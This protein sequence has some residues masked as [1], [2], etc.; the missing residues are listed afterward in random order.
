MPE[1]S[2]ITVAYLV[3]QYPMVSHSFIRREIHALEALGVRV[4]RF[5]IRRPDQPLVDQRD[6]EERGITAARFLA[7]TR[8][9]RRMYEP[10]SSQPPKRKL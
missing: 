8:F 9:A 4:H 3:N 10:L 2:D 1:P 6:E 5:A 7:R